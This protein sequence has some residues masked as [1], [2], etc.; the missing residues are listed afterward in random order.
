M[1][2]ISLFQEREAHGT[3]VNDDTC[4][5]A[6]PLQASERL[7]HPSSMVRLH[8]PSYSQECR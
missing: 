3:C 6:S 5:I 1:C 8:P 4:R 7:A 2:R